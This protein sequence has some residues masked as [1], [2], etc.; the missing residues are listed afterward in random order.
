[1]RHDSQLDRIIPTIAAALL[2]AE[3]LSIVRLVLPVV[4][5]TVEEAELLPHL[6]ALLAA[7]NIGLETPLLGAD[8]TSLSKLMLQPSGLSMFFSE[9]HEHS[10]SPEDLPDYW[11]AR[12]LLAR[13][14][15]DAEAADIARAKLRAL[16]QAGFPLS[17]WEHDL[18][19][20]HSADAG[21]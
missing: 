7:V 14:T 5:L 11:V 8:L 4:D 19:R 20:P 3:D 1:M 10:R 16:F 17:A 13:D 12:L 2:L 21:Q 6:K 9:R 15:G 18:I